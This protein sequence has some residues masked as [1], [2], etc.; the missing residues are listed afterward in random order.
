MFK[1]EVINTEST[2]S[3]LILKGDIS[4]LSD[5]E[6][7][8]YYKAICERLGV[9]PMTKPFDYLVLQGKQTL[10]LNKGGAEQ[11]SKIHSVSLSIT[12]S[13]KLDDIYVVTARATSPTPPRWNDSTGAVSVKNLYGDAL[14][15]A[16]MKAETKA[17]R[18][19]TIGLLGLAMLDETEI[20]TIPNAT[21]IQVADIEAGEIVE[22]PK[23]SKPGDSAP[24]VDQ[25]KNVVTVA[26]ETVAA[27]PDWNDLIII[28]K[29]NRWPSG[30]IKQWINDHKNTGEAWDNIYARGIAKF[31]V[32]N[33]KA[34]V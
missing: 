1:E 4:R 26:Q 27:E 2:L 18:R 7:I 14:C 20:E 23:S 33:T 6:K 29:D 15:N 11:L 30:Y 5:Q 21:K 12:E 22:I 31:S 25:S 16:M 8:G 24:N 17:K 9:D 32:T 3:T 34:T 19:A 28:G 13:K 10:Y